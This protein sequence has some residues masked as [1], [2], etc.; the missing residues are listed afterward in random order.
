MV[1]QPKIRKLAKRNKQ[2]NRLQDNRDDQLEP[3]SFNLL[4]RHV[5]TGANFC[6]NKTAVS[7]NRH[8]DNVEVIHDEYA[9]YIFRENAVVYKRPSRVAY[10]INNMPKDQ[11]L[12]KSVFKLRSRKSLDTVQQERQ[13]TNA[14]KIDFY[15]KTKN[16]HGMKNILIP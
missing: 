6:K 9:E 5:C 11:V 1:V 15:I 8:D 12:E 16:T 7:D 4:S 10:K 3:E 2:Y 14:P 13:N